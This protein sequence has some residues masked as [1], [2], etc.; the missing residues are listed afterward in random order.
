MKLRKNLNWLNLNG[1]LSQSHESLVNRF[2]E[3]IKKNNNKKEIIY[4][5]IDSIGGDSAVSTNI[6]LK[7]RKLKDLGWTIYTSGYYSVKSGALLIFLLGEKRFLSKGTE[8]MYHRHRKPITINLNLVSKEELLKVAKDTKLFEDLKIIEENNK[9]ID[10][11][12]R[13]ITGLS[14]NDLKKIEEKDLNVSEAIKLNFATD[15]I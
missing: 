13:S 2:V 11:E 6:Y 3:I 10:E 15:F 8:I 1:F 4:I 7:F 14:V 5:D 9:K 12:I